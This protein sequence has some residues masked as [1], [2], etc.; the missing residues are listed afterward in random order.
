MGMDVWAASVTPLLVPVSVEPSGTGVQ[1][2]GGVGARTKAG[3]AKNL[4]RSGAAR[5]PV[6]IVEGDVLDPR[7]LRSPLEGVHTA[8]YLVHSM[9]SRAGFQE[10]DRY[11]AYNFAQAARRRGGGSKPSSRPAAAAQSRDEGA[12]PGLAAVR[13]GA[14][15]W[16]KP[17]HADRRL[18]SVGSGRAGVLVQPL[19]SSLA[20]LSGNARG[21]RASGCRRTAGGGRCL[22]G[23]T[24]ATFELKLPPKRRAFRKYG[25]APTLTLR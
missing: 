21:D 6:P 16:G 24:S 11:G 2:W 13:G 14:G 4:K 17:D 1:W 7:S 8:Y 3:G 25:G 15:G 18:R 19:S 9:G 22:A 20:D 5:K 12:W 10:R 23:E